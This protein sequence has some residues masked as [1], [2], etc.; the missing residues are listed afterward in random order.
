[1]DD[2]DGGAD[3]FQISSPSRDCVVILSEPF[4]KLRANE[5]VLDFAIWQY[6]SW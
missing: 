4:D 3:A 5:Q 6:R 1:V 2:N